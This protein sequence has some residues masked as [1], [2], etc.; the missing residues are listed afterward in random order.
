MK[1]GGRALVNRL[2]VAAAAALALA[3][4][5][6]CGSS[7]SKVGL[8]G[9]KPS[10]ARN[11]PIAYERFA[12]DGD[13]GRTAQLYVRQPDGT[14]RR[15]THI[16]GGAFNP[17]WSFDGSRIAFESGASVPRP[18]LASAITPD[19]AA[20]AG[21]RQIFTIDADGSHLHRLTAACAATKGC[22]ADVAPAWSPDGRSIGFFRVHGPFVDAGVP[23]E[24]L[25][26][27]TSIDLVVIGSDGSGERVVERWGL[28]PQPAAGA[29]AWSPDGKQIAVAL[30]SL[31][32]PTKHA[33]YNA[34]IPVVPAAGGAARRI[35]PWAIGAGNP[36]WSRD[37]RHIAFNS[38]GGHTPYLYVVGPDGQR[39]KPLLRP[40]MIRNHIDWVDAPVWSPDGRQIAFGTG[41]APCDL[42]RHPL[43][44][45]DPDFTPLD[46]YVIGADGFGL[47]R[48]TSAPQFESH[49]AW[50][51]AR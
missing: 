30:G 2:A 39:L 46:I 40:S 23:H 33:S 27:A 45:R 48:L 15:I 50:A 35:S 25:L 49:P 44:R 17:A 24:P 9:D 10:A 22:V 47:R 36:S 18:G 4:L 42:A 7:G 37:G 11:G 1:P 38:F 41:T 12:G 14:T 19:A 29:P 28:D 3:A 32:H 8:S 20:A 21:G 31:H 16:K 51:P 6:A 26:L 43:C 13:D 34:A 5:A